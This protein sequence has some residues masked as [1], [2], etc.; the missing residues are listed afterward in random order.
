[1]NAVGILEAGMGAAGQPR[2]CDGDDWP[3][4]QP[5][6]SAGFASR[7]KLKPWGHSHIKA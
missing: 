4:P 1:M 5:L 6:L 3:I 2:Q 7:I